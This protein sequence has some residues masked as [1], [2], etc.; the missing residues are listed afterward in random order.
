[1]PSG[2]SAPHLRRSSGRP[3]ALMRRVGGDYRGEA[4]LAHPGGVGHQVELQGMPPRLSF[5]QPSLQQNPV[6]YASIKGHS[7]VQVIDM[8][9]A[10]IEVMLLSVTPWDPLAEDSE[11]P[12]SLSCNILAN[13]LLSPHNLAL[14]GVQAA[15]WEVIGQEDD[16][17]TCRCS[18]LREQQEF[19]EPASSPPS[20]LEVEVKL[21]K[22]TDPQSWR[23]TETYL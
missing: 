19:L 11:A 18:L 16:H 17:G 14:G 1:V 3:R 2:S 15:N 9:L 7:L 12:D 22:E 20:I 23:L 4:V 8:T 10:M 5:R 6:V 21:T 13:L